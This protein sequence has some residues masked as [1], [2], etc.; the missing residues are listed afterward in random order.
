MMRASRKLSRAHAVLRQWAAAARRRLGFAQAEGR[1]L[2]F[3]QAFLR[4]A[5]AGAVLV[6]ALWLGFTTREGFT[7][8]LRLAIVATTIVLVAG[9]W[10]MLKFQR[11]PERPDSMRYFGVCADIL[12]MTIGLWG[13]NE[14]GVPLVGIY[15]W[16][17]VGNGFRF[18]PRFLLFAYG[19]SLACFVA[20]IL[21]VPYWQEHRA[22]GFGFLLVLLAI[23]IYVLV[24]L[25]RLTA[26]KDAALEL[27]RAK[28][29]FVANVSHELR[30]PLT[31]V[32]AVHELLRRRRLTP[33]ER[34]LANSMGHA[35]ATLKASVDA[36]LQ[37]TKLEAGAE[38]FDPR[39]FNLRYWLWQMSALVR[40]QAA[41]KRLSWRLDIDPE[42]PSTVVGDHGHLQ[43]VLGN[44][45]NNALKFTPAGGVSLHVSKVAAGVRFEVIDTGIGIPLDAQ[46]SLF[47]RF[48]QVDQSATRRYGGT[49]L[50]TSIAAD[51]VRLMGGRIGVE[52]APEQGATFWVELP[53]AGRD[54]APAPTLDPLKGVHVIGPAGAARDATMDMLA[55]L[56]IAAQC[57]TAD[58]AVP[59]FSPDRHLAVL[60]VMPPAQAAEYVH[61][62]LRERAGVACPWIVVA[63]PVAAQQRVALLNAGASAVL[64]TMLRH[65]E[66][67]RHLGALAHRIEL[68]SVESEAPSP[69]MA[70][71][72]LSILLAD[73]NRSNQLLLARILGDAGH[74]VSMASRGDEAFD[75]MAEGGIDVALLDMNMP[76]MSGP[77]VI[78]LFRAGEAGSA[79]RLPIVIFSAD[80]T[81]AAREE[82]LSAGA[83][84]YLTKPVT[85]VELLAAIERLA[86][87]AP[88]VATPPPVKV[89][90]PGVA[91]AAAAVPA[92]LDPEQIESLRRIARNDRNFLVQYVGAAFADIESALADLRRAMAAKDIRLARDALH[93]IDGTGSSLGASA[94]LVQARGM[95]NY[96][97][98][99]ADPE[100]KAALAELVGVYAMTKMAAQ[101]LTERATSGSR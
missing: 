14:L 22:I 58:A 91:R 55:T 62:H 28:T 73:D 71:R 67:R 41:A 100:A 90:E 4:A 6:Y 99:S 26:Q 1:D 97:S 13:A 94:L 87:A 50:G 42:V 93:K 32:V 47:E 56:G 27:L 29:R 8:G 85:A 61:D 65:S 89:P 95:R 64:P 44:L 40:P 11:S 96:L 101:S 3:E 76:E 69:V 72:S 45:I 36:V 5:I 9:L 33:D 49:G 88:A 83:N 53:L 34:D 98:V 60:L 82:S 20:L 57:H 92:L 7:A 35:I 37:M 16:V 68:P 48:V 77:D 31:G 84:D 51:F 43:H 54:D 38:R 23:P 74:R 30:T 18:G 66:W 24:L 63:S 12:P 78:R 52:S 46:E 39:P 79:Q 21:F 2:D 15:L 10:M 86:A 70:T 19:L 17:T 80:A 75:L 25:S 59:D 81:P